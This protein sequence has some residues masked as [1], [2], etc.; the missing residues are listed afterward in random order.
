MHAPVM[1]SSPSEAFFKRLNSRHSNVEECISGNS[2][3]HP[4]T[5][6]RDQ[7]A[8]EYQLQRLCQRLL[9]SYKDQRDWVAVGQVAHSLVTSSQRISVLKEQLLNGDYPIFP[10]RLL[11]ISE[12]PCESSLTSDKAGHEPERPGEEVSDRETE[13][14]GESSGAFDTGDGQISAPVF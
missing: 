1:T 2:P 10:R 12:H 5:R 4:A 8:V 3:E 6:L 13:S 7:L 11:S 9:D 14:E